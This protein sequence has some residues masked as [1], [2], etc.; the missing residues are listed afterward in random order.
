VSRYSPEAIRLV[1]VLG[2]LAF[3]L[4]KAGSLFKTVRSGEQCR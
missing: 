2:N 4:R 3:H 1:K